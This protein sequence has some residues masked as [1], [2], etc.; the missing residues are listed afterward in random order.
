MTRHRKDLLLLL[1]FVPVSLIVWF[2]LD[3][4]DARLRAR[5]G[6]EMRTVLDTAQHGLKTWM[7]S[8]KTAIAAWAESPEV[9]RTVAAQLRVPRNPES[10]RR[11]A[12]QHTLRKLLAPAMQQRDDMLGFLVLAPDTLQIAASIDPLVG[13]IDAHQQD[14]ATIAAALAGATTLGPLIPTTR[15]RESDYR[16][17]GSAETPSMLVATPIRNEDRTVMAVLVFLLDPSKDFSHVTRLA[18]IGTTGET[19][20]FTQGGRLLTESRFPE[21]LRD[22]GLLPSGQTEIV[23]PLRLDSRDPGGNMIE[24]FRPRLSRTDQ[25]L[26]RMAESA[27][28]GHSGI[29]L[30]GYRDY[31]GVPVVGA[32]TWDNELQIGLTTEIDVAEAY[33]PFV[34]IRRIIVAMLSVLGIAMLIVALAL[35]R[36][37]RALSQS[38]EK[39]RAGEEALRLSEART[40]L[41]IDTALDA[42]ISMDSSGRVTEWSRQAE[43]ILGWSRAEA[44]GQEIASLIVPPQYREAHR[45]GLQRVL[46]TGHSKVVNTRTEITALHRSGAEF[47]VE[48]AITSLTIDGQVSFTAFLSDIRDRKQTEEALRISEERFQLAIQGS[49]DG[50]WDWHVPTNTVY[51]SPRY[52][53]LL[54]YQDHEMANVFDSFLGPVHPDDVARVSEELTAHLQSGAPYDAE[55]R[56]RTRSG[57]YRWFRARGQA[58]HQTDGRALRMAGA[59]TDITEAKLAQEALAKAALEMESR[60][61][62]VAQARDQALAATKAKSQFLA[63]MSHEIR[64]P[65]NAIIGMTDL[66]VET[67]LTD[68]QADY[69]RRL[70]RAALALLDLLND[71]LDLSK[72]EAGHLELESIAFHLPDLIE[73]TAELLAVKAQAKGLEVVAHIH[74]TVPALVTGDPTRVRQIVVNLVSNAV[75]FTE[76]GTITIDVAPEASNDRHLLHLRV[77]D[78]GIGIPK[79]KHQLIFENFTQVDSSTTRRYGGTGLGLGIT[80]QLIE[81]MGGRIWVDS[82]E[83]LGSTFHVLLPLPIARNPEAAAAPTLSLTGQRIL[84]VDDH[85]TNRLIVRD[86][87][88]S[89]GGEALEASDGPAAL[90]LLRRLHTDQQRVHLVILDGQMPGMDGFEVAKRLQAMPEWSAVPAIMLTSDYR[91]DLMEQAKAAGLRACISKP[92]RRKTLFQTMSSPS[93]WTPYRREPA[94]RPLPPSFRSAH[95]PAPLLGHSAFYWPRIWRITGK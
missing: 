38:L 39:Q 60:N 90:A 67:A 13:G 33:E 62:E 41:I 63:S 23:R 51:Y 55:Y 87:V 37:A 12:G 48:L 3:Q 86:M 81:M 9:K 10:L 4:I 53:E 27:L 56:L 58:V 35:V 92:I 64:T 91:E 89:A 50:I 59:I 32:W 61:R 94:R 36:R 84:I 2:A 24:G 26:T 1:V 18:R 75:K 82:A 85:D 20:A 78:T 21:Q 25:P 80:K 49:N 66:L 28:A 7:H 77:I 43:T 14:P 19:Y 31:R 15:G 45:A 69:L 73:E 65:M 83:G 29:D 54:G 72:I 8:R 68:A 44:L 70:N 30:A 57:A 76:Q 40:R 42:V 22:I 46:A 47:P 88:A 95:R 34:M 6:N 74:P 52:K 11:S 5:V 16:L 79:E 17:P 93:A 71:I